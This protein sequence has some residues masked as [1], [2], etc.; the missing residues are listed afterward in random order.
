MGAARQNACLWWYLT[1]RYPGGQW[2][3]WDLFRR[4]Y[5][6]PLR[7]SYFWHDTFGKY[8]A[9]LWTCR[10]G[11][12]NP[13]DV[14]DPGEQMRIYCFDCERDVTKGESDSNDT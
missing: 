11:C 10:N 2:A 1:Y 14:S 6:N 4:G 9:R 12:H 5:T 3:G 8:W 7:S 13:R